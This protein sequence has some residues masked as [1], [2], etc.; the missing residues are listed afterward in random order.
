M[1]KITNIKKFVAKYQEFVS[2]QNTRGLSALI[3][4]IVDKRYISYLKKVAICNDAISNGMK[5]EN[6]ILVQNSAK[7][8][9][10]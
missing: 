2:T 9:L 8:H 6:G 1:E 3:S 7:M 5:K 4:S 10:L